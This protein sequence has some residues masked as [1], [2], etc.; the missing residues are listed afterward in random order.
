[1]RYS[2]LHKKEVINLQTGRSLGFVSDIEFDEKTGCICAIICP[3]ESKF[4]GLFSKNGGC[5]IDYG[6]IVRIGPDFI[7]TNPCEMFKNK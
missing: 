5:R 3:G 7:L 6:S 2:E 1:M 4:C